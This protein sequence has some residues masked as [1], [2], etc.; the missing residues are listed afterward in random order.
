MVV[1]HDIQGITKYESHLYT[2]EIPDGVYVGEIE[3]GPTLIFSHVGI[4]CG[5][6]F[7]AWRFCKNCLINVYV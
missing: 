4:T 1:G 6:G 5:R 2:L 7:Y 3:I